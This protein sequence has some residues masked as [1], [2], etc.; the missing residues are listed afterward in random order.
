MRPIACVL[1]TLLLCSC[2]QRPNPN[3]PGAKHFLWKVTGDSTELW[4]LG[5]IHMARE[6]MYPLPHAIEDAFAKSSELGVEL[7]MED[8]STVGEV[9]RQMTQE[10]VYPAGE[11][12]GKHIG[13]KLLTRLDSLF[14]AWDLPV[15]GMHTLRPWFLALRLGSIAVERTGISADLGIDLHFMQQ[16]KTRGKPV[17]ALE[18]V[19]EQVG[20]FQDLPDSLQEAMLEW[21][22][23]EALQVNDDVDSMFLHWSRGDTLGI[24]RLVLG[25]TLG[26]PRF[27]V[28]YQRM[29]LDRNR[30][31]ADQVLGFLR[32]KRKVFVVVGAAHLVGDH[33]VVRILRDSG[34]QVVQH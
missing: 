4:L 29:Y 14:A 31:M 23:T 3:D 16:A 17:V 15:A 2:A 12:L 26:D 9:T 25:S 11:S 18:T 33:S 20:V 28:I 10:G 22:L 7:N 5:S 19:G 27:D 21:T 8:D 13:P 34:Y 6:E 24:E 32:G 1:A 30:R